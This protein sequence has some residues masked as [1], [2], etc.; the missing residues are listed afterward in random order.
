MNN[1]LISIILPTFNGSKYIHKSIESCI[2]QSYKNIELIIVD[3]A[4]TDNV[5]NIIDSYIMNDRRIKYYKHDMNKKLPAALNTGFALSNGSYLTWTSDDNIYKNNAIEVMYGYLLSNDNYDFVFSNM[6]IID[7]NDNINKYIVNGPVNSISIDNMVGACFLYR[8]KVYETLG[9]YD[10]TK[11]LVLDWDYWQRACISFNLFHI[12]KSLYYF[13]DHDEAMSNKYNIQ[14]EE[15]AIMQIMENNKRYEKII[16]E[17]IRFRSYLRAIRRSKNIGMHNI[18]Y[19]CLK[20]ALKISPDVYFYVSDEINEY[21]EGL[22][23]KRNI[24]NEC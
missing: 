15:N 10:T 4:S 9:D 8:R 22:K 16:P 6:E 7:N 1:E 17:S 5:K 13:R 3:D 24:V 14:L 23:N 18:A 12:P 2:T 20:E 19:N 11:T 21:I